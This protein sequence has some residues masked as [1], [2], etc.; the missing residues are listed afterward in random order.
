MTPYI[1]ELDKDREASREMSNRPFSVDPRSQR[2]I[3]RYQKSRKLIG[4]GVNVSD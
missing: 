1:A 2:E 3:K 4:L